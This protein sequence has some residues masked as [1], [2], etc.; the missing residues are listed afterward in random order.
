VKAN[1]AFC[2][3]FNT[4]PAVANGLV[5]WKKNKFVQLKMFILSQQKHVSVVG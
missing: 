3:Q 2:V 1:T 5:Q 4:K